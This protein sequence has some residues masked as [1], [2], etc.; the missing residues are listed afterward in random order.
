MQVD[1][2]DCSCLD[3]ELDQ[4]C[5]TVMMYLHWVFKAELWSES[6]TF[7][8]IAVILAKRFMVKN[9]IYHLAIF[10]FFV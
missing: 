9:N 8:F 7:I 3:L 4:C 10:M 1:R 6:V 2:S 5:K